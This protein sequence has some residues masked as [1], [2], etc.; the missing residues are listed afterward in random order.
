VTFSRANPEPLT[1]RIIPRAGLP[2]WLAI[3]AWCSLPIVRILVFG[4]VAAATGLVADPS[5]MISPRIGGTLV[6]VYL[7]A[8]AFIAVPIA[9]VKLEEVGRLGGA[10][11]AR[12]ATWH[13][14]VPAT[15]LIALLLTAVTEPSVLT[16]YSVGTVL[17]NPLSFALAVL[18]GFLERV[19]QAIGLWLSIVALVTVARLG[20]QPV[21][22]TFPE[23]RSLGL[24]AVGELLATILFFY[25]AIFVP[26]FLF[27]TAALP[28]L[29][30]AVAVFALV[31][32]A[33][34]VAA[35]S[36]HRRMAAERKVAVGAARAEYALAYRAAAVTASE[37]AHRRLHVARLLLDGA[38]SIH[39]WP[40]DDR[41]QRIVG[42]LLSGVL[43]GVV[44][45][46]VVFTLGI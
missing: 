38:E 31:L 36:V 35:W 6:N 16:A 43:T 46:F 11:T 24:K 23:D 10:S 14:S 25:V 33:M 28:A 7:I 12:V 8:I 45:R 34:L 13:G 18:I 32:I 1:E 22:G 3:I 15:L 20:Q 19:P 27:G 40:F 26:L 41:T 30:G 29:I 9:A 42:I 21:P 39:E 44:V 17:S 5:E 4:V 37:S 2:R